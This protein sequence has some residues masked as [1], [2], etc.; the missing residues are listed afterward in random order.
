MACKNKNLMFQ[1]ILVSDPTILISPQCVLELLKEIG[2]Y[3]FAASPMDTKTN[4]RSSA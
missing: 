4:E 1:L 3:L 2:K